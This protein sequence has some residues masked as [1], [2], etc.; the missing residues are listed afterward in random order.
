MND[1][2][3]QLEALLFS[4]GRKMELREIAKLCST[5]NTASVKNALLAMQQEYD[6]RDTALK[7][8]AESDTWRFVVK[9]AYAPLVRNIV[10]ETELSRSV[11]ETL[12]VIAW[13]NPALQADVIHIR[14]NKAYDHLDMLEEA[15]YIARAKHGRTRKITLTEKFFQYFDLPNQQEAQA[16]FKQFIPEEIR[17][18]VE[19]V[20]S[21]IAAKEKVLEDEALQKKLDAEKQKQ[22]KMYEDVAESLP[23][24]SSAEPPPQ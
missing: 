15:G 4:S 6:A 2:C 14:T 11:M 17:A 1:L 9:D 22:L 20:E 24:S 8:V 3:H 7:I 19:A 21:D 13:K 5:R 18:N 12:A 10:A 16:A 23:P